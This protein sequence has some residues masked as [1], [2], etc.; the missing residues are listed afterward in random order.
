MLHEPCAVAC[1]ASSSPRDIPPGPR[2][3]VGHLALRLLLLCLLLGALVPANAAAQSS[4]QSQLQRAKD[5]VAEV[6]RQ[7]A[8]AEGD[9]GEAEE[10]LAEADRQLRALEDAVNEAAAALERQE[11][12]AAQAERRRRELAAHVDAL[13]DAF[14]K[15]AAEIYKSGSGLPF[16]V[17]LSAGDIQSA[18]DRSAFL[19]VIT[20]SDRATLEDVHNA[21]IRLEAQQERADVERE[22]LLDMR[23]RNE[24]LLAEVA[25]L[26]QLRAMAAAESRSRLAGLEQQ[27]DE[28]EGD[29]D[30]IT[31]LIRE[32]KI[33][34]VSS[35]LP[36]TAGY[37]WPRC[38][39]VTSG[40]GRR[41]GR[42]HAGVDING[43]T[44]DYIAAAKDGVVIFAGRQS[45]YGNLT[46]VDHRDGI[47]T[48]YAHQSRILVVEGQR[49]DRGER[50]GDVGNTGRS[51]GPHL[52][53]ETR[54]NGSPVDPRRYLPS[55]C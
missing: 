52:H 41:W 29:V 34:P 28:L 2:C 10:A 15:R 20:S 11:Q 18:I 49:V 43:N 39:R 36:S 27:H 38:D 24:E 55:G 31:T 3:E 44:G 13:H 9:L 5:R 1:R 48:A 53:F 21:Q 51:T 4:E 25:E 14:A 7:I 42:L 50:I 26:R 33:T 19:R 47:V 30:R 16:Q 23:Q 32:R 46:L 35:S 54:L 45:G 37:L 40:F 22:R 8:A 6:A 17:V 12:A